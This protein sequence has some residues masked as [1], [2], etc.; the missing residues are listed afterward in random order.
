MALQRTDQQESSEADRHLQTEYDTLTETLNLLKRRAEQLR[1][2]NE[3]LQN[4]AYQTRM[5]SQEYMSHMSK[6]TQ[7]RQS[8]IVAL[9]DQSQK[10]LE[11]LRRQTE[12]TQ[13]KHKEQ[14]N[15]LKKEILEK[16]KELA[17]L[18]LEI[19]ELQEFKSLQQGQLDHIAE[20][21]REV[22]AT[23]L[24]HSES[25]QAMKAA[26]LRERKHFEAQAKQKV[27]TLTLA[28]NREAPRC[29]LFHTQEVSQEN[30]QLREEL[31][32]LIQRA[33]A[34]HSHQEL[35]RTQQRQLLLEREYMQE[36][37][38]LRFPKHSDSTPKGGT[39]TDSTNTGTDATS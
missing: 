33:H 26:F 4:E 36:L 11:E 7:K 32:Q 16:E 20:L 38:L 2:D 8:A 23:H 34:L 39:S 17:L 15:A 14:A 19:A 37:H 25:L 3:F 18:N 30:Q 24:R 22:A 35:L 28:G 13:E 12:E 21:E 29:L 31:Q 27:Q 10:E 1:R 5:E 9:S 6:R